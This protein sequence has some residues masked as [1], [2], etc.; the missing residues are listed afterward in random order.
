MDL[1]TAAKNGDKEGARGLIAGGVKI[2]AILKQRCSVLGFAAAEGDLAAVKLLLELGA[3]ANPKKAKE[4]P[5]EMALDSEEPVFEEIA[6]VLLEHGADPNVNDAAPLR[7]ALIYRFDRAVEAMLARGADPKL[8]ELVGDAAG[9]GSLRWVKRLIELGADPDAGWAMGNALREGHVEVLAFLLERS[10]GFELER[11]FHYDFERA[12]GPMAEL[13]KKH[14]QWGEAELGDLLV[15]AIL[16]NGEELGMFA[17]SSLA[18]LDRIGRRGIA[19]LHAA[20]LARRLDWVE[21]LLE[22]GAAGDLALPAATKHNNLEIPAG[23]TPL[24]LATQIHKNVKKERG[25][26][27]AIAAIE[28]RLSKLGAGKKKPAGKD[29]K[30]AKGAAKLPPRPK[31]PAWR[32]AVDDVLVK[33]A[34]AG[35]NDVG[36]LLRGLAAIDIAALDSWT[37]LCRATK[38]CG[39][40]LHSEEVLKKLAGTLL[41]RVLDDR[42]FEG[43]EWDDA[44]AK[45]YPKDA[46][47]AIKKGFVLSA[48]DADL[49]VLWPAKAGD[50][51]GRVCR[52]HPESFTVVA[53]SVVELLQQETSA[54]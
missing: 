40:D 8:G 12:T 21:R 27:T 20:V 2:D 6:L 18:T 36:A 48:W 9:A 45:H 43:G 29:A 34:E 16:D 15:E 51:D 23:A 5:L 52:A 3:S 37:Y 17:L 4:S 10:P 33:V 46:R 35:G 14:I 53:G 1:L 19:P 41:A 47:T 11:F 50:D 32:Q 49:F 30:G 39:G 7:S 26:V 24:T 31:G 54:L 22:K 13:V 28:A 42:L 38:R 25:D 44:N